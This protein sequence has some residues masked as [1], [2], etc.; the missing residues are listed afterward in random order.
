MCAAGCRSALSGFLP[1]DLRAGTGCFSALGTWQTAAP[2]AFSRLRER[3]IHLQGRCL[4]FFPRHLPDEMI[5]PCSRPRQDVLREPDNPAC[6]SWPWRLFPLFRMCP[7]AFIKGALS[8]RTEE[9]FRQTVAQ[10]RLTR[11]ITGII[12][13]PDFP[14]DAY[15][16]NL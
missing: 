14:P 9:L 16:M 12:T 5:N 6:V 15:F 4:T 11:V 10:P 7:R 13:L 2:L 3:M 1:E 8:P